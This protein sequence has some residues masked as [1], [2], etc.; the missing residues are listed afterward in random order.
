MLYTIKRDKK[1]FLASILIA[2]IADEGESKTG[3]IYAIVTQRS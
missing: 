3:N 1:T 2:S